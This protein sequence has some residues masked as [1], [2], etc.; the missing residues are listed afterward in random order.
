MVTDKTKRWDVY[1]LWKEGE[2]ELKISKILLVPIW[3]VNRIVNEFRTAEKAYLRQTK[4]VVIY[5]GEDTLSSDRNKVE[6]FVLLTDNYE[7]INAY[8]KMINP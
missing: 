1:N 3:T 5:N 7:V 6:P 2:T 4:D 8:N